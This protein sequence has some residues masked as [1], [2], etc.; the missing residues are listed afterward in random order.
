[1]KIALQAAVGVSP[2][3]PSQAVE[4]MKRRSREGHGQ[5][6]RAERGKPVVSA[7]ALRHGRPLA[8]L[9]LAQDTAGVVMAALGQCPL[10]PGPFGSPRTQAGPP[11]PGSAGTL[12]LVLQTKCLNFHNR[13]FPDQSSPTLSSSLVGSDDF[14]FLWK[15]E[16][17]RGEE[18]C[19]FPGA[20]V[21]QR[22][23]S[24]SEKLCFELIGTPCSG[25]I[26]IWNK[27]LWV[28]PW[29]R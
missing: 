19:R 10:H 9:L 28:D 15:N 11:P 29:A 23:L 5:E 6:A 25:K 22:L 8:L 20:C 1:M 18:N 16:T 4:E 17:Q 26:S 7:A 21:C 13:H 2:S 14:K 24:T 3:E 27:N 12:L